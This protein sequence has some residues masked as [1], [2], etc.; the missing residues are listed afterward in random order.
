MALGLSLGA[1]DVVIAGI[2]TAG[3][4]TAGGGVMLLCLL[5]LARHRNQASYRR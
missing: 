3:I 5:A 2:G 4:G 1:V